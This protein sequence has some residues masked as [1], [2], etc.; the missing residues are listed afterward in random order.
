MLFILNALLIAVR[1]HR[2][3]DLW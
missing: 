1:G 3:R 2:G